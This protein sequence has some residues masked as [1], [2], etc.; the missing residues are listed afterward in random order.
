MFRI[1]KTA[2]K[3]VFGFFLIGTVLNLGLA[4]GL[5]QASGIEVYE[6]IPNVLEEDII[7]EITV[8]IDW[9]LITK[10]YNV[11]EQVPL[12]TLTSNLPEH[13]IEEIVSPPPQFEM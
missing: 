12:C 9:T 1:N 8:F 2:I 4:Y 10:G 6:E 3:I 11:V 13:K 5:K 7:P